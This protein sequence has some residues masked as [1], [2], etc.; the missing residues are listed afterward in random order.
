MGPNASYAGF[1]QV[2]KTTDNNLFTWY[3]PAQNGN[4]DAPL[5]IWLQG[6]CSE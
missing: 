1:Y 5:L 3:F 2:N 6:R 4:P